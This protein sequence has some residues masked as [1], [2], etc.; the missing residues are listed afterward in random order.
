MTHDTRFSIRFH[1]H[2]AFFRAAVLYDFIPLDWPGYLPTVANRMEYIAK[3]A[4]LRN[5]DLFFP[6]SECT[7][8]RL[9]ELT[10]VPRN[11][12]HV[13]GSAVR[14]SLYELRDRLGNV[15]SPYDLPE[16]YFVTMAGDGRRNNTETALK[17]V[18]RLNRAYLRRISLKVIGDYDDAYK[19]DLL[20]LAGH[21]EGA[22]FLELYPNIP[23]DEVVS[24]HAGAIA[25]IAPSYIEGFSLPLA[26]ASVCGCPVIASTCAAH[27]EL[28]QQTEA[29]FNP[30]DSVALSEK[31]DALLHDPTLRQS[32][33]S[34]QAH[35]VRRFH[36]GAVG[37]RFWDAIAGAVENSNTAII[38]RPH[39]PRLAFLSPY[40][41]DPSGVARYTAMTMRAGEKLFHSDIYTDALRPH[42]FEDS[43]RDA[44]RISVAPLVS[45]RYNGV[46]CV[47]GN[48][49]YHARIFDVFERYGGPCILH[50]ARLTAI[51][52]YRLGQKRFLEF[53]AKL[54]GRSV[55]M[56][57]VTTWLQDRNLP[58]LFVEPI[59]ERASPLIVHS[60]VQQTQLKKRYGANAHVITC[61]PT[62]FFSDEDLTA[63]AKQAARERLGI[64]A[65]EFLVSSFGIVDRAKGMESCVLAVEILRSWNIPA[66]LYFIGGAGIQNKTEV[67]RIATLYGIATHVHC[68]VDFVDGTTYRDFLIASDAAVQLRIYGF[69]QLSAALADCVSAGLP[70]VASS[71]LAKS[72]DAPAYVSTVPDRF[73]PLQVAEQLALIWEAQ[74][75]RASDGEAR[76]AYLKTHNFE[77]YAK[78][79]IEILGLG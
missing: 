75:G 27:M 4:R 18:Q 7:A 32:L 61:C 48:S 50:D 55:F 73:S 69:G 35:L 25:V 33:V 63:S 9:A 66:E 3:L 62:I 23:D 70:C 8:S 6:I 45:G 1:S 22:G 57:E 40:P 24:M 51:Y 58:S 31:L 78:R 54:L 47:L 64:R 44:G 5:F 19:F 15:P 53:A 77:Y 56:E 67:D 20:R 68:G 71:D 36:E 74:A 46:V 37:R 10:G 49:H 38:P 21:G 72:C 16:P 12:M 34:S 65:A 14:R 13:T 39:K 17:A 29:L 60:V 2:P 59:I 26:E 42:T 43:S 41:P 52:F 79:L 76:A 28:I 30:D 11:R